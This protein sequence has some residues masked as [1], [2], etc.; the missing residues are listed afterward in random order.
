M[1]NK[2]NF[3]IIAFNVGVIPRTKDK[4]KNST[5]IFDVLK[6]LKSNQIYQFRNEYQ[7]PKNDFSE[8]L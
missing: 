2:E 6:V 3:K 5:I 8:V 4:R 1:N 7:F